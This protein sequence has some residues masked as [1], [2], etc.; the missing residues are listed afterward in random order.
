M[1]HPHPHPVRYV[2]LGAG[3]VGGV[4]GGLLAVAGHEVALLARGDHLAAIR[5]DGLQVQTPGTVHQL[6]L[7]AAADPAE[8]GLR[9]GDV[10]LLAVKGNDTEAA[11]QSVARTGVRGL[12]VVCL[13]NGVANERLALRYFADVY[14]IC[15]MLPATH[16]EPGV[17]RADCAPVPGILDIGRIPSGLD[18]QAAR[19]SADLRSA[20]F[21]SELREHIMPWKYCKLLVNLG[22][23]IRA[24]CVPAERVEELV[25]EARAEAAAVLDAAGIA[26]VSEAEDRR[27][28]G[29]I[30]QLKG[31]RSGSSSWQSLERGTG[32]I[33]TD[34]LN[35]EIVQ[36][37]RQLGRPAPLNE[38]IQR[39][40]TR[41]A[42]EHRPPGTLTVEEWLS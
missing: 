24:V 30:L 31:S 13:Q 9:D 34:Y 38:R 15:V 26:Y 22:N 41:F 19:I 1:S 7:D 5:R 27:R 35:G 17:V 4:V 2:I 29:D 37:A 8:L 20:G 18:D 12:T 14:G 3:A 25:A 36:L 32:S 10:V 40:A 23:G 11:L 28:R 16:L 21:V 39:W 6:K 42:A 33:E